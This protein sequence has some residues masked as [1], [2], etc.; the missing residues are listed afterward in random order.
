MGAQLLFKAIGE[1]RVVTQ[2]FLGVLTALTNAIAG[3]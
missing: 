3:E 1:V 2:K